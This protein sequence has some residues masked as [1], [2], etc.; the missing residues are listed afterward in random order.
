MYMY[1]WYYWYYFTL[2]CVVRYLIKSIY[3]CEEQFF[4]INHVMGSI[5][6]R[7]TIQIVQDIVKSFKY[8]DIIISL[9]DSVLEV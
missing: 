1:Y 7:S 9:E 5:R 8:A 6:Y 4:V 3:S 2:K